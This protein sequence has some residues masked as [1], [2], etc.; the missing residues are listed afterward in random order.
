MDQHVPKL[1]QMLQRIL[2]TT[3]ISPRL[4]LLIQ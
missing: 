3:P 2:A 1:F 4:G